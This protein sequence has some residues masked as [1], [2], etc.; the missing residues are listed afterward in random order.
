MASLEKRGRSFRIVFRLS[1][2]EIH[3]H[4]RRTLDGTK[5]QKLQAQ[6]SWTTWK[7][8]GDAQASCA[9]RATLSFGSR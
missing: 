7:L 1:V 8:I 9:R 6:G 4:F 5:W 2:N 3:D